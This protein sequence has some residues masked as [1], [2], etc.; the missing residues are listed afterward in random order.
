MQKETS[1]ENTK[2]QVVI[3]DNLADILKRHKVVLLDFWAPW[4]GPCKALAPTIETLA[5]RYED[6]AFIGQVNIDE[7]AEL[8][9]QYQVQSIP[10]LIFLKDGEEKDRVIGIVALDEL[11]D[12]LD[13][14]LG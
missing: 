6:H 2:V 5:E 9:A 7:N 4:C 1:Q 13:K 3:K 14:L 12:K 8:T 10:T 11:Q